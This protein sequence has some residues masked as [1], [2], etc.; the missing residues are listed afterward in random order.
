MKYITLTTA[1]AAI[2]A[3]TTTL[4]SAAPPA[5]DICSPSK[6]PP[7]WAP[8]A[9]EVELEQVTS[10]QIINTQ[11]PIRCSGTIRVIDGCSFL[12]KNFTLLGP[13]QPKWY[14][15]IVDKDPVTGA[16]RSNDQAVTMVDPIVAA[17]NAMDSQPFR[18]TT[19]VG[20]SY[21]WFSI[22]EMRLFDV[23][24]NQLLCVAQMP[25]NNPF[26]KGAAG[27]TGTPG[28]TGNGTEVTPKSGAERVG[29]SGFGLLAGLA[30]LFAL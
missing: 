27:T 20:A 30:A 12:V 19:T 22:N 11:N 3:T 16:K 2:L 24:T 18:L 8:N 17:S 21:S 25:Y 28:A 5:V 4:V 15:G 9:I 1:A 29:A 23:A 6:L 14:G 26:A 10:A 7:G 13:L